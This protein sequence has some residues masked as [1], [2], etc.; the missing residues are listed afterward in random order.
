MPWHQQ[1]GKHLIWTS[2]V[3]L[4]VFC[5]NIIVFVFSSA[6]FECN[7]SSW[8]FPVHGMIWEFSQFQ[9]ISIL[10]LTIYLNSLT[11]CNFENSLYYISGI[12]FGAAS[13]REMNVQSVFISVC[14][15]YLELL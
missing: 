13:G 7:C 9:H 5:I 6:A 4:T 12:Q 8:N 2:R 1:V 11:V 3:W 10:Y 15:Y 14:N